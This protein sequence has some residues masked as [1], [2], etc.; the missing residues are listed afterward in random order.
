LIRQESG[1]DPAARSAADARGLMQVM[2][3]LGATFA[4]REQIT[5]WDPVL[6]Y[7]PDLNVHFGLAHLAEVLRR[8]DR[9]EHA[10]AAYNAGGTPVRGWLELTGT[11][12]DP[13]VFIERIPY[14]ETR[15][16]VR[17]VLRNREIYRVLYPDVR[18]A[19]TG[20]R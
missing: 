8:Y 5:G 19:V 10:L 4:A 7:Q 13:E 3:S 17:I 2:P 12:A 16:Y 20:N 9:V 11:R 6:L 18:E 1:F 14:V 15:D